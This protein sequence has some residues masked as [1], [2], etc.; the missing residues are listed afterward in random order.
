MGEAAEVLDGS[1]GEEE[2][3]GEVDEEE[4]VVDEAV[5]EHGGNEAHE[6]QGEGEEGAAVGVG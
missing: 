1:E 4:A 6:A 5:G 2:S 3:V